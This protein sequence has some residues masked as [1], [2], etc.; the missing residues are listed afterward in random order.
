M[1]HLNTIAI[2]GSHQFLH[3][4]PV[5]FEM[6]NRDGWDVTIFVPNQDDAD[7]VLALAAS[8][9]E[10][11]PTVRVLKLPHWLPGGNSKFVQLLWWAS[12]LRD[13][14][15]LLSAE[16]TS[17]VLKRMPGRCPTFFH[18]PHGAGD[19]AIGFEKRLRLFDRIMVAGEKDRERMIAA[20]V[21]T[22]AV[23][24]VIGGVK[25]EAV[26]KLARAREPLFRNDRP[27][28]LYNPHFDA[29]LG[30]F[31]AFV[32]KLVE[33][34]RAQ[35]RYNLIVAP[36]IRLAKGWNQEQRRRWEALSEPGKIIVDLGSLRSSDMTYT[37]AANLYIGD[38]SSQ[39]YE[40]LTTAR[41]CLFVDAHKVRW[42]GNPDYA[43]WQFGKVITPSDAILPAIEAALREH[44]S[45]ADIQ[46]S[47]VAR[48]LDDAGSASKRAAAIIERYTT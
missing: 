27:T 14:D 46:R 6:Q 43:M 39:V 45:F 31:D 3:F 13:C 41:P 18:I 37:E 23:C 20:G 8:L 16:R 15:A 21:T 11:V 35:E 38:V 44:R 30:S 40:F 25:L 32:E 47:Q 34:I 10:P 9:A 4:I 33:T 24:H 7:A 19:R 26:A 28:I 2:G 36:H 12:R 29:S 22:P 48:A 1:P 17:T 42:A 5:A